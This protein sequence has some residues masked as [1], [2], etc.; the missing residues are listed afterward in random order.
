MQHFYD[1]QI[2]RYITQLVRLM[3]NFSY[4]DGKGNL[5]QVPVMYGD[6][7][8]QVGSIIKDNSENKI[9]SA[10]RIGLY[11]TGLEMDRTRTADASYTG[12]VHIRERTYD[13]DNN[14]YLNTQGK[15][16]TVE[17]MMPTPFLLNVNADI[18]STNTEQKLQILE[19]LL[20][21]FNPSLEIQTTDNYVDW[22]SLSVVNLENINFSS[23]SIPMGT[24]TEIDVATLGFQTPIFI[25]PPAK[26]KKLGIITS[27]IM[28]IFDETK[29]TIDL[30]DSMPE[31]QAYDDSWNNTVKNKEKD[32]RIHIQATTAAGYD[33][34]V[35]NTI[36]Q[37]G[38]NG[39]SGEISWRTVLESE[40]GEYTAGLSQ[41]YLNR[42]DLGAPI[43][44][45]FAL[46]TL[47]ETQIIVNWDI[48]TIPTNTVM[49]LSGS[50][51]KGTIDAIID[52]TRTNPTSLKQSGVRILLL[53]DIGATGNTDGADAWKNAGGVDS[54]IAKENDIIEWSGTEW[55]IVFDSSTKTD[56]ATD[57]TYTTNLNTGVQYKWDGLEWTLSFEGEY[58]KGSWR[59]VL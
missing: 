41:I 8:R 13:A 9:P 30:G 20:M 39:I 40:P 50:P 6:I 11:V 45:T 37:L 7:T 38:K 51:Q 32:G 16:Y 22:T 5:V 10:P 53:G 19:Q 24:E 3:S 56:T 18:W 14:E 52:P 26:V 47:D 4:K 28:S 31:L 15:N 42:I 27:V 17:R 54:L 2:R 34:I 1:G 33:A 49:G 36:V 58:R 48:D 23:R 35:T 44:G 21:L 59:I 43:V 46:N 29:G 57:V 25:S 55:Q 12:K